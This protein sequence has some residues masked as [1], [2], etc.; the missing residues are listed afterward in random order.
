MQSSPVAISKP[1]NK[2][3]LFCQELDELIKKHGLSEF[4]F[5]GVTHKGGKYT[6]FTHC[7]ADNRWSFDQMI[8]SVVGAVGR[9]F[10]I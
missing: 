3:D 1:D 6:G 5:A 4:V 7:V 2:T 10:N 8:R 9:T